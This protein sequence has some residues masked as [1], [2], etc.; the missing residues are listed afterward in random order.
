MNIQTLIVIVAIV[1]LAVLAIRYLI[2]NGDHCVG[3]GSKCSG[4][5]PHC[6][7]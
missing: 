6:K 4:N 5:C 2:I 3:C 7:A 1:I